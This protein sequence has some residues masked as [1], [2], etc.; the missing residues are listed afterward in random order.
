[1]CFSPRASFG[2]AAVLASIGAVAITKAKTK[3]QYAV[4]AIP[5]I[6][7]AQQVSEGF[8]WL[9][10]LYP[11]M[12]AVKTVAMNIFLFFA[13]MAWP[14][15]L[16][17]VAIVTEQ[18]VRRRK[19]L[20]PFLFFGLLIVASLSYGFIRY[21]ENVTIDEDHLKYVIGFPL[22]NYWFYG[23]IYFLPTIVAPLMSGYK[24]FRMFGISLLFAYL[25]SRAFYNH[26]VISIWCYF[27]ALLSIISIYMVNELRTGKKE[28]PLES[29]LSTSSS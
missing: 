4:A 19:K 27:G 5:M 29:R 20:L 14:V 17:F 11:A 6:F 12:A 10:L 1:M 18:D 15:Y 25:F 13:E 22:V 16:P 3:P 8:V 21:P 7:A 26:Y 23:L 9:S 2:A 24:S 28:A